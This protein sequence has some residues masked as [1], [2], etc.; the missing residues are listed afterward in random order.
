MFF[1]E[2]FSPS[3]PR[4]WGFSRDKNPCFWAVFLAVSK[5]KNKER[6]DR[7]VNPHGPEFKLSF[8]DFLGEN[9]QNS[10]KKG[11][12]YECPPGPYVPSS[13]PAN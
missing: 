11:G 1:F 10:E 9:D 2:R 13:S 5:K 12:I 7:V 8:A 4:I 3:L 6:K